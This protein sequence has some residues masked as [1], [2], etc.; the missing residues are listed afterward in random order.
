MN[1]KDQPRK[2][3]NTGKKAG[4]SS[5]HHSPCLSRFVSFAADPTL[6]W[7]L[8]G[9]MLALLT[10]CG[11][12]HP[13]TVA[14]RGKVTYGGGP[15]PQSGVLYFT[16]VAAAKGFPGRT[17]TARFGTDGVFTAM[18]WQ[19][20]DGLMPGRYHVGVECWKVPPTMGGPKP[21]SYVP[22]KF[23]S[24]ATSGIEL[25]IEPGDGAKELEFDVPP[26]K[27]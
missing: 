21:V 4:Q 11:P 16:I 7:A 26:A 2:T 17:G 19:P 18:S 1:L 24:A 10:G 13:T 9:L 5:C 14:V 15:W 22:A 23:Q 25:N 27:I 20:G 12:G 3:R 8:V 6:R